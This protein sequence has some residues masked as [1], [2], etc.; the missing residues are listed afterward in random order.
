MMLGTFREYTLINLKKFTMAERQKGIQG[1]KSNRG[2]AA[3]DPERQRE[4]AR[5]GGRAA[6]EQGVAHEFNSTEAREAGR[7]G[8]SNSR[9]GSRS[10]NEDLG[11]Q[12]N[13]NS[14]KSGSD[15]I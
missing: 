13:N 6:H 7:K 11:N 12:G 10:G 14:G 1:E 2:F 5:E 8:G 3:M 15:H 4:I 9:R